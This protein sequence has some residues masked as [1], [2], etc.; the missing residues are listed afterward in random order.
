MQLAQKEIRSFK[1]L[2]L[3]KKRAFFESTTDLTNRTNLAEKKLTRLI[4][5]ATRGEAET[6]DSAPLIYPLP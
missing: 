1:E 3:R 6:D 4:S 2:K 5:R